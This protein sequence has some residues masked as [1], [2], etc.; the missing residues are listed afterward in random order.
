MTDRRSLLRT[1]LQAN[2][3][4]STLSGLVFLVGAERVAEG[5]G[6]G[7]A[8]LLL[9]TGLNLLGFAALLAYLGSRPAIHLGLAMAVVW[10]DLAWVVGTIPVVALDLLN[11]T[12]AIAAVAIAD[13]VLLFAVLQYLGIRR[14]RST[15]V[16]GDGSIP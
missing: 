6:L 14:L 3:I 4:F 16:E 12:G 2:A 11:R 1:S 10:A 13:V 9:A 5:I 8:R 15:P 7:D